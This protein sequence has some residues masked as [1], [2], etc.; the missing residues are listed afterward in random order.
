MCSARSLAS[1][2]NSS[3]LATKSV[4][5][6][7]STSAP[8][9]VVEVDVGLD[10]PL[11]RGAAGAALARTRD[12]SSAGSPRPCRGRRPASASAFLH[13]IIPAPVRSRSSFTSCA[14]ISAI[15]VSSPAS[16]RPRGPGRVGDDRLG[17][18]AAARLGGGRGG[19]G[20]G[21]GLGRRGGCRGGLRRGLGLD[22]GTGG[23]RHDGFAALLP[24]L[25]E[26]VRDQ[27]GD[28]RDRTDRVVV[29]RDHE[30]DLVGIAVRV[31]DRDHRDAELARL[32]DRDVLLLRVDHEDRVGQPFEAL[33]PAEVALELLLLVAQA[34]RLLLGEEVERARALHLAELAQ[35]EQP[36]RDRLE[37]REHAAEPPGRDERHADASG[38]LVDDLLRLLLRPDEQDHAAAAAE[39]P[40]VRV[41]LLE[42]RQGLLEVDDVDP[43]AFP[44]QV[45][46]HL[47]VPAPRL[48]PEVH[49]CLEELPPGDDRHGAPPSGCPSARFGPPPARPKPGPRGRSPGV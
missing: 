8:T 37:V 12:P 27:T 28:E 38:V 35:A 14:L 49:P 42:P 26:R 4:S 19:R 16:A 30:V 32:V 2:L 31:H 34:D 23:A 10:Q 25:D 39:I 47:R 3:V 1:C 44:V 41:G 15:G 33:H 20:G 18:R 7:T 17:L 21:S 22:L 24:S 29:A 45:P 5:Q 11:V 13:S 40:R 46:A 6:L 48:V 9:R 36:A 43:G